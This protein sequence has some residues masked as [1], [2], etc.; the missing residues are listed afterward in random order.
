MGSEETFEEAIEE[1]KLFRKLIEAGEHK[2]TQEEK[3]ALDLARKELPFHLQ[4]LQVAQKLRDDLVISLRD[5]TNTI[6]NSDVWLE[7]IHEN[8]LKDELSDRSVRLQNISIV[9]NDISLILG[10][11][12]AKTISQAHTNLASVLKETG[13]NVTPETDPETIRNPHIKQIVVQYN[14]LLQQDRILGMLQREGSI[15]ERLLGDPAFKVKFGEQP[16]LFDKMVLLAKKGGTMHD[17]AFRMLVNQRDAAMV[18]KAAQQRL[19]T[20]NQ[21]LIVPTVFGAAHDMMPEVERFNKTVPENL[22][23][24]LVEVTPNRHQDFLKLA[25]IAPAGIFYKEPPRNPSKGR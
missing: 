4:A 7:S 8:N 18:Q 20:S 9:Q 13:S 6:G 22:K 14:T 17:Q 16:E 23:I 25:E 21:V 12:N 15:Q 3:A 19:E 5:F 10:H 1:E 24:S 11:F 2:A